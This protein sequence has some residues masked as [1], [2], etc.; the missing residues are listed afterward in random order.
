MSLTSFLATKEVKSL[1]RQTFEFKPMDV[2]VSMKA[3]P[4]TNNYSI[5]G[6]AFDYLVRFWLE[7]RHKAVKSHRWVAEHAVVY[8]SVE[9][10][11]YVLVNIDGE[12]RLMPIKEWKKHGV[13]RFSYRLQVGPASHPIL[14]RRFQRWRPLPEAC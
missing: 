3:P 14:I 11:D 12:H 10:G 8:L 1:F 5:V 7:W 13:Q 9:S 4:L 6:N 2:G